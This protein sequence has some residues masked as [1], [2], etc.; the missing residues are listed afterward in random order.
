MTTLSLRQIGSALRRVTSSSALRIVLTLAALFYIGVRWNFK[1]IT[2]HLTDVGWM[3][4]AL[5]VVLVFANLSAGALRWRALLQTFGAEQ[6]PKIS[7]LVRLYW[8][9]LFYNTFLP[10]N[11]VGDA[12]RAHATRT[13]LPN[14]TNFP[15]AHYAVVILER[16]YGLAALF[17]LSTLSLPWVHL[18][19]GVR[20]EV[21]AAVG[22]ILLIGAVASPYLLLW[23]KQRLPARLEV[24]GKLVPPVVRPSA[25][26][27]VLLWS[28]VCQLLAAATAHLLIAALNPS[29]PLGVSLALAPLAILASQFP[30]TVAG[31]GAR[32]MAF[33]ALYAH[34]NV[35]PAQ[36]TAASLAYLGVQVIVALAGGLLS[37][38]TRAPASVTSYVQESDE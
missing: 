13:V 35:L 24:V 20:H 1:I 11:V 8:V 37:L 5:G 9:G 29:V 16:L 19:L 25:L 15:L 33:V 23:L 14:S 4:C 10:G 2:A 28:M 21:L 22:A 27:L 34:V 17:L 12:L 31:L 32:E 18:K 7:A 38:R 36:A 6:T 3:A 30:F 26:Y